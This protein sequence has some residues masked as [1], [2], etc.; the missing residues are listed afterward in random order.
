[1]GIREMKGALLGFGYWGKTLAMNFPQGRSRLFVFDTSKTAL[2]QARDQGFKTVSSFAR[3]LHSNEISFWVIAAPP[4][5][6]FRLT[7]EGLKAGRHVL[8]EKPFGS[9]LTDKSALFQLAEKNKKV[10]MIDYTYLYSPGFLS[11]KKAL[12][13]SKMKSYESL[14]LNAQFPR[15]DVSITE[16]LMIHDLSMLL[17]TAPSPPL[18]CSCQGLE[19][20]RDE[21]KLFQTAFASLTGESWRAF[22]YAGRVFSRKKRLVLVKSKEMEI[23]FEETQGQTQLRLKTKKQGR[24][25][26]FSKMKSLKNTGN[27]AKNSLDLVFEEF[28]NRI[29]KSAWAEDLIR[30][31]NISYCLKAL[32]ISLKK[33]GKSTKIS[34]LV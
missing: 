6:H 30:H 19:G 9:F 4:S 3:L 33:D 17:E 25:G 11:L 20:A 2:K 1:M 26:D 18:Y 29:H 24:G 31:K 34:G 15:G 5:S 23:E 8:A 27:Q 10:L 14:R 21:P 22:I 7:Q 32:D 28:F 13:G 16:D 12:R